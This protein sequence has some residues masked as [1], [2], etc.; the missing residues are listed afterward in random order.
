MIVE[1]AMRVLIEARK[2]LMETVRV[3][4]QA[5]DCEKPWDCWL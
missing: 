5:V 3:L 2:I 1:A 4:V